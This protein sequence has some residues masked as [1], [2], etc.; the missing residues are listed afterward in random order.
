[1]RKL[2]PI[3][4]IHQLLHMELKTS[5][6]YIGIIPARGGSKG[7]PRKNIKLLAGKP[8]IV[9]TIE[10]ALSSDTLDRVVVST[11]DEEIA[12]IALEAGA[13]VPFLR[14]M[15]L[16][17]D[18]SP[19]LDVLQ[20]MIDYLEIKGNS[21]LDAVVT[22]QPTSPLRTSEHIDRAIQLFETDPNADSLVSCIKVPH[23][24][25]PQSVMKME[26]NGYLKP[27]FQMEKP[28]LN[29]QSKIPVYAR[30]GA[31]ICITKKRNL[32]EYIC[33]GRLM[34]FLM[35]EEDSIDIDTEE[36]FTAAETIIL[37][38]QRAIQGSLI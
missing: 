2:L 21:L 13:E 14:P 18:D 22:L 30:N 33:G 36:D 4:G 23:I 6:H 16:A 15:E 5:I 9:W 17:Q 24:F 10:A 1:M 28:P 7:I 29:R 20:N 31:A 19:T 32:K 27:F 34:A 3:T 38:R 26:G 8:L 25:N 11:E 35:D 12:T 37:N